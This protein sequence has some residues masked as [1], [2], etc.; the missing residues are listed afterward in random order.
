[1]DASTLHE[2]PSLTGALLG[3]VLWLV[4][5]STVTATASVALLCFTAGVVLAVYGEGWARPAGQALAAAGGTALLLGVLGDALRGVPAPV[6]A[7]G[8]ALP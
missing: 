6:L 2:R 7:A 8:A 5:T 3:L 4:G 1:M